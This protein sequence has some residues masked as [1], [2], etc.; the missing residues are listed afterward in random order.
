VSDQ[1]RR[2]GKPPAVGKVEQDYVRRGPATEHGSDDTPRVAPGF[3]TAMARLALESGYHLVLEG[4]LHTGQYATVRRELIGGHP[5]PVFTAPS[6]LGVRAPVTG[7][8]TYP[9]PGLSV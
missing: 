9:R 2:V 6:A 7:A 1:V 8:E 4:I 5:G 3:V